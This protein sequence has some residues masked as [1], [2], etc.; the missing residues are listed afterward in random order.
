MQSR[1]Y[2]ERR[3]ASFKRKDFKQ[4]SYRCWGQ[5]SA[6]PPPLAEN[7]IIGRTLDPSRLAEWSVDCQS[8]SW[9]ATCLEFPTRSSLGLSS[10]RF[11][12]LEVKPLASM[13]SEA[14]RRQSQS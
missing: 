10:N 7:S 5:P 4:S 9:P 14:L 11:K 6:S 1:S 2:W 13:F 3:E 12:S 8:R